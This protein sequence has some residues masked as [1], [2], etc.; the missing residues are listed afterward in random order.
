MKKNDVLKKYI[1]EKYGSIA[2]FMKKE[3]FPQQYLDTIFRKADIFHE[4]GIAIKVCAVLDIDVEKLFCGGEIAEPE[5]GAGN[6]V[7]NLSLDEAIKEKYVS[8]NEDAQ[9][10]AL[11]YTDFILENGSGD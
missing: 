10:K 6:T 4:I 8:L 5:T 9:R 2:K 1:I 11:D 7:E 3:N